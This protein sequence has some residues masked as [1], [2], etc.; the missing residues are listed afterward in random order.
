MPLEKLSATQLQQ[1]PASSRS[2]N[3][4]VP[5]MQALTVG[6]GG[7]ATVADEGVSREQVK[8]RLRSAAKAAGITI[9]FVPSNKETV[10]FK[11]TSR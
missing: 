1:V 5:F 7:R 9:A 8:N 4:Y 6:Q 10:V 11:V 3:E 2:S